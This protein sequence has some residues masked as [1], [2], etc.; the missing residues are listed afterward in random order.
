MAAATEQRYWVVPPVSFQTPFSTQAR[1]E[2]A[3]LDSVAVGLQSPPSERV[4]AA[5]SPAQEVPAPPPRAQR[6]PTPAVQQLG[7]PGGA[8]DRVSPTPQ[9]GGGAMAARVV[10]GTGSALARLL[11]EQQKELMAAGI[12]VPSPAPPPQPQAAA[13][14]R[15]AASARIYGWAVGGGSRRDVPS[16]PKRRSVSDRRGESPVRIKARSPAALRAD[17]DVAADSAPCADVALKDTWSVM[18]ARMEGVGLSDPVIDGFG[19]ESPRYATGGTGASS[20]R[21]PFQ[22]PAALSS[23]LQQ[24][25]QPQPQPQ[26]HRAS[27]AREQPPVEDERYTKGYQEALSRRG[28]D[29]KVVAEAFAV[30]SRVAGGEGGFGEVRSCSLQGDVAIKRLRCPRVQQRREVALLWL[31][32]H[33]CV[34][35]L[36]GAAVGRDGGVYIVS[37]LVRGGNLE[38]LLL[39]P[40]HRSPHL[41]A[42]QRGR[43]WSSVTDLASALTHMHSVGV[44]HSDVKPANVLVGDPSVLADFGLAS[45]VPPGEKDAAEVG[46]SEDYRAPEVEYSGRVTYSSDVYAL[47]VSLLQLLAGGSA[48]RGPTPAHHIIHQSDGCLR[49]SAQQQGWCAREIDTLLRLGRSCCAAPHRRPRAPD[50]LDGLKECGGIAAAPLPP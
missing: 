17:S 46:F 29:A 38:R 3:V 37:P 23:G 33:R 7:G 11:A 4:A 30:G 6:K 9:L 1:A 35:P 16:P 5:A 42:L 45:F 27:A 43:R 34:M 48:N 40:L 8:R 19:M 49:V 44:I 22:M 36:T 26:P 14:P 47:G 10:A 13:A 18:K 12:R 32:R 15:A 41:R 24:P 39:R 25:Q 2:A 20:A 28:M 21:G 31:C 50:I